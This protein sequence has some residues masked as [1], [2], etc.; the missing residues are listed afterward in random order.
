MFVIASL[1]IKLIANSIFNE[2]GQDEIPH[3][4]TGFLGTRKRHR[5]AWKQLNRDQYAPESAY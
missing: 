5:E 3:F 4:P 2:T 1:E